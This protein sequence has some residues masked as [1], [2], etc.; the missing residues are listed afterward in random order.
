V[1]QEPTTT[2]DE[3]PYQG[4]YIPLHFMA[5]EMSTPEGS[6][7]NPQQ[8]QQSSSEFPPAILNVPAPREFIKKYKVGNIPVADALIP[9]NLPPDA[10][11]II[12][13]G[14][15]YLGA[16]DDDFSGIHFAYAS[17]QIPGNNLLP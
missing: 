10:L 15:R 9:A 8:S 16:E 4:Y 12:G 5:Q 17:G 7:D 3:E 14:L 13:R 1:K 6:A 2:T 11:E